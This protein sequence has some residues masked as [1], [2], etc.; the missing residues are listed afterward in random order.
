LT[1]RAEVHRVPG[2]YIIDAPPNADGEG[3]ALG[4]VF[5]HNRAQAVERAELMLAALRGFEDTDH[6]TDDR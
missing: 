4:C 5:A 1:P 2:G 6:D 3:V